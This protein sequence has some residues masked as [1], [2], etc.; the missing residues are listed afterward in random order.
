MICPPPKDRRRCSC[1]SAEP[2]LIANGTRTVS[3]ADNVLPIGKARMAPRERR[4]RLVAMRCP[5]CLHDVVWDL[6]L[7]QWWDLDDSDYLDAGS[8]AV[9]TPTSSDGA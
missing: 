9:D 2:H 8:F 1:G 3:F 4:D 7:D 5:D 6:A